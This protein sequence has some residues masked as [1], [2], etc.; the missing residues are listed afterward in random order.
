MS[1]TSN[2][3]ERIIGRVERERAAC[4]ARRDEKA[5]LRDHIGTVGWDGKVQGLSMALAILRE[6]DRGNG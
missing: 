5:K 4:V 1:E 2:R 3:L 6:V